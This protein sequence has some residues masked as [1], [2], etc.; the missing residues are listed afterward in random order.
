MSDGSDSVLPGLPMGVDGSGMK[1]G[2]QFETKGV[3]EAMHCQANKPK[4]THKEIH[5]ADL[6]SG[7]S[8]ETRGPSLESRGRRAGLVSQ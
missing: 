2:A 6:H 4:M 3:S 1:P 5:S 7:T 8:A